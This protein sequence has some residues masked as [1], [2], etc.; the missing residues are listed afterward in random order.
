M[1]LFLDTSVLLAACGSA[2][3]S[4]RALFDYATAQGWTLMA[5]PWVVAE[6]VRNLAK[7]PPAAT[8]EWLRLRPQL[9]LVD[10]VVSLNQVGVFPV[11]KDRPVLLT[12]LAWSQVL[13]TLDRDDFTGVLGSHF[14][15]LP[16]REP[17]EF[18][19]NERRAG[20]LKE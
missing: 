20:R 13:L 12:A 5:S 1:K 11:A 14:Y 4:S 6:V 8:S 2:R 16:L 19:E 9:V 3:G 15:G 10:D 18:L 17:A 7:F